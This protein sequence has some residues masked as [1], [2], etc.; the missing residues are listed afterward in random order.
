MPADLDD[1]KDLIDEVIAKHELEKVAEADA[2]LR[3]QILSNAQ[4]IVDELWLESWPFTFR[5]K[6]GQVTL[7]PN[8]D[9][10]LP[11][12]FQAFG[13]YGSVFAQVGG[14]AV[15]Q[16]VYLRPLHMVQAIR[17]QNLTGYQYPRFCAVSG[18]NTATG[19]HILT[20]VPLP[21]ANV[22]LLLTYDRKRP[23]LVDQDPPS[24]LEEI[25]ADVRRLVIY[26]GTVM[27]QMSDKGDIRADTT[28]AAKYAKGL[29]QAKETHNPMKGQALN[30]PSY[31]SAG[32]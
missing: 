17:R 31:P 9:V 26:E 25:P 24:G 16:E 10:D 13:H 3:T 18:F 23:T 19:R 27:R 21:A 30:M 15:D 20:C 14:G 6:E 5:K 12:D 32:F 22:T 7:T 4:G 28:Q 8:G 1:T 2:D 11:A 29:K